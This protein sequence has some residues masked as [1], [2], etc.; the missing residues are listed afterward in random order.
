MVE[1]HGGEIFVESVLGK[2]SIF[3]FTIP[4]AEK[5]SIKSNREV[6]IAATMSLDETLSPMEDSKHHLH[7]DELMKIDL[8]NPMVLIVDDNPVNLRILGN[9]LATDYNIET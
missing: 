7:Q 3:S 1:L 2:G 4:L 9:L 5:S 8:K 6:E